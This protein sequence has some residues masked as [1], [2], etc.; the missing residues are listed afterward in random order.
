MRALAAITATVAIDDVVT[1]GVEVKP[2]AHELVRKA[3]AEFDGGWV[4]LADRR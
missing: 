4:A 2:L 3:A 1:M